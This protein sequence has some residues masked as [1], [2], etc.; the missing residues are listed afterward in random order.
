LCHLTTCT[1][2]YNLYVAL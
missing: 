1:G 2:Q